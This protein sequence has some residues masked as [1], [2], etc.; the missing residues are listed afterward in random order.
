MLSSVVWRCARHLVAV[1]PLALLTGQAA[2]QSPRCPNPTS[3]SAPFFAAEQAPTAPTSLETPI[4]KTI[5]VGGSKGVNA[6]REAMETAPCRIQI[7]DDANE[8]LGRPAFPFIKK[9]VELDLVV[10]SVFE[11]GFGDQASRKAV[12]VSLHEIYARAA[13]LGFDLCP[14]EVGPALRLNYLDQPLGEFLHIAM[15]PVARYTGELVSFTVGAGGAELLLI[16]GNGDPD[17]MYPPVVRFV[18]VRPRADTIVSSASRENAE[19]LA[20]R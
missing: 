8:I 10:L 12:Q 4:W 3:N 2:G 17:V 14:A 5:T 6:I 9:P 7:G 16:G 15:K 20:K 18:F 1:L 11:L 13:A 19:S